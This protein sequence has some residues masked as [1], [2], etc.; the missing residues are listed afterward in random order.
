MLPSEWRTDGYPTEFRIIHWPIGA[1]EYLLVLPPKRWSQLVGN[2]GNASLTNESAATVE[3]FIS[4]N[5]YSRTLD[6]Y[7]RLPLPE[8]A[9]RAVAINGD[10][11]L[12]GRLDK[13]EIWSPERLEA[14]AQNSETRK[15]LETLNTLQ[16]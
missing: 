11:V 13:F 12:L 14:S 4:S 8:E 15:A 16:L 7:G 2:L 9:T 10:A 5:S 3:R 6:S 1:S